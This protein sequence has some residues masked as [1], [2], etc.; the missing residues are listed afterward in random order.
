VSGDLPSAEV[1]DSVLRLVRRETAPLQSVEIE[2]KLLILP[3][4]RAA[5]AA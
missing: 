2:D 1:R 3:P 5:R 4:I